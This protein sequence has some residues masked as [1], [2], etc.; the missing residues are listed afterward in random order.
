MKLLIPLAGLIDK[1]AELARLAKELE[2]K[3]DELERCEKKLSN[4][5]F[6]DKAP[7]EVVAKEQARTEELQAAIVNLQTQQNK[8]QML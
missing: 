3:K 1:D 4:S 8:I 2:K 5:N 7:Q 6:I